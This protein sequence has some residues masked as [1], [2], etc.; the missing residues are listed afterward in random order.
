VK[1]SR[2]IYL[3]LSILC[4]AGYGLIV[5]SLV[6]EEHH[7]R[8]ITFCPFKTVTGYPCPAC[9]TTRATVLLTK[10]KFNEAI[11]MNP[12]VII[13]ALF[14]LLSPIW[15]AFDAILK[16]RTMEEMYLKGEVFL[17]KSYV[18]IPLTLLLIINWYWNIKK[19][20]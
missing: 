20:L 3:I 12:L 11:G 6:N 2:R 1:S 14:L 7:H 18:A 13:S 10:G 15:I 9:G 16:K 8:A 5:Y 17:R 4:V 19:G